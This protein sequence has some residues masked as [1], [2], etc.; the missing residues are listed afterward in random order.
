MESERNSFFPIIMWVEADPETMGFDQES[1]QYFFDR[2]FADIASLNCNTVRPSN[3]PLEYGHRLMESAANHGLKVIFDPQWGNN[4]I[5]LPVDKILADWEFYKDI[6]NRE[7]IQPFSGYSNLLGYAV[8]DE[9]PLESVDQWKLIVKMFRELDPYHP[10]YTCFNKPSILSGVVRDL[11]V[12][13]DFIVYDNY[14][15]E[16]NVP[17]NTMGDDPQYGWFNRYK[18]FYEASQ[19]RPLLPNI[20]TVAV[21]ENRVPYRMPTPTEFRTTIFTS[22]AAGARGIMFFM[23]KDPLINNLGFKCLVDVDWKP[24]SLYHKVRNTAG[25]LKQLGAE[26][27]GFRPC[28]GVIG[29]EDVHCTLRRIF[30]KSAG[31]RHY[32]IANKNPDPNSGT[33]KG[34]IHLPDFHCRLKD[35]SSGQEFLP[36]SQGVVRV[37]L[38]PAFG[39][40]LR[41]EGEPLLPF[42]SFDSPADG[43]KGLAGVVPVTGWALSRSGNERVEIKRSPVQGEPPANIGS[44]GLVLIGHGLFV[45][46]ARS[47]IQELYPEFPDSHRA[48]W[49]YLMLSN[50]LP[51]KGNGTYT[52]HAIAFDKDGNRRLLG[53][54]TITCDNAHSKKP[55][56]TIETPAPGEVISGKSYTQWGWVLT[57]PYNVIPYDGSTITV[58]IDD[59]P[60]SKPVTYGFPRVDII[61]AFPECLNC[62]DGHGPFGYIT[63]D[64]TKYKNGRHTIAW[65]VEDSA[66][67]RAGIGSRYFFIKNK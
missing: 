28:T 48:G 51:G 24:H 54:K 50:M 12:P 64:T 3:L 25:E 58:A 7:V 57:P 56:G 19:P 18:L 35:V 31:G 26:V 61:Q 34:E 47:D 10:D 23:Y 65:T 60:L 67:N 11:N 46:G 17:L 52:F 13:M 29:W 41:E 49:G 37:P 14:P 53:T 30:Q 1:A 33:I 42:G 5:K 6:I 59:R 39:R 36:D 22:L 27:A 9:P 45:E 62:Q 2:S 32:I 20:S 44:D 15:H 55:F 66:G 4:L 43:S 63:I 8:Y 40:V 38:E 21:F 16:R